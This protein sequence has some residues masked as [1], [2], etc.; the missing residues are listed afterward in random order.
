MTFNEVHSLESLAC[1]QQ[2][3]CRSQYVANIIINYDMRLHRSF[4]V[5][6]VFF[7]LAQNVE[8]DKWTS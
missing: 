4:L 3:D 5:Q 1:P 7:R 2:H 6:A 8:G